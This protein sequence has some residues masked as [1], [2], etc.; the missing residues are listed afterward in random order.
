MH[1]EKDF[2]R[3]VFERA[4]HNQQYPAKTAAYRIKYRPEEPGLFN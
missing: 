1:E 4:R 3:G 2:F